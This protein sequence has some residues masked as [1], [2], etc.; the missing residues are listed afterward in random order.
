MGYKN[1][2]LGAIMQP[3]PEKIINTGVSLSQFFF[4]TITVIFFPSIAF[5]LILTIP[6][7]RQI[8]N[9]SS[10]LEVSRT[11]G[12][13]DWSGDTEGRHIRLRYYYQRDPNE[14]DTLREP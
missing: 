4:I 6:V 2:E 3:T 5:Y 12:D 8:S 11:P 1:S 7:S 13:T 14:G 10:T 9:L